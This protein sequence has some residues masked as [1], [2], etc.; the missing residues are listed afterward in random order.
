MTMTQRLRDAFLIVMV[1]GSLVATAWAFYG[2]GRRLP[3]PPVHRPPL[4]E[5]VTPD[6]SAQSLHWFTDRSPARH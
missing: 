3:S 5:R 4:S 2:L 6:E 1:V